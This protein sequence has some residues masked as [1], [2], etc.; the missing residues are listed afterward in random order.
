MELWV[1]GALAEPE[2]EGDE[3]DSCGDNEHWQQPSQ[4]GVQRWTRAVPWFDVYKSRKRSFDWI[5]ASRRSNLMSWFSHLH[6]L[7]WAEPGPPG[8]S[9]PGGLGLLPRSEDARWWS[10]A[11]GPWSVI[12]AA[13]GWRRLWR[14]RPAPCARAERKRWRGGLGSAAEEWMVLMS[15]WMKG[16]LQKLQWGEAK[17]QIKDPN[18][19]STLIRRF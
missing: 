11:M 1:V 12:Q 16:R 15:A 3:D 2:E 10:A 19:H 17:G 8:V 4:Q 18:T 6:L 14:A 9:A 7:H 13:T 5:S